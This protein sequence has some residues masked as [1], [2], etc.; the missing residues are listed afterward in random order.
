M[1]GGRK[2]EEGKE[3]ERERKEM[4]KGKKRKKKREKE[5]KEPAL[6]FS[7]W[8]SVI[9]KKIP[10]MVVE[11]T[12]LRNDGAPVWLTWLSGCLWLMS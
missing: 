2:G 9:G 11:S 8:V 4:K 10:E 5:K 12:L 1:K 7:E 6:K 3:R